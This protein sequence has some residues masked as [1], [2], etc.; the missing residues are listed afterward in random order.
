MAGPPS[1]SSVNAPTAWDR[2]AWL[3]ERSARADAF[4]AAHAWQRDRL[5]GI[6]GATATGA[7]A[8]RVRELLDPRCVAVVTGQQPAVGGGPL[9]TVVKAAHAIA[10]ARGL[11][12]VG[13]SAA[14]IFWCASEDHDLGE[15]DHA[16]IIAADG[17]IHRFHGDLG[18][19]R[20]SLRFRPARSWWSA[21][22]AHC[23]THLGSGIGEPYIASLVPDAEETMGAWHCRLLSS[24]FAQHGLI[25]VEGHRLRPLWAE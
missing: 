23:R 3:R 17:S 19:G 25:C 11:S 1:A 15:A 7:A 9:Y 24:L 5:V 10:I 18:G 22:I 21:L 20:G 4:L 12:E 16:D 14:P 13:R 6:L 2:T 8:A